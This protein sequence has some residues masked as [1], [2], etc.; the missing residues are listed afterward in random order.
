MSPPTALAPEALQTWRTIGV[1]TIP[2]WS[3]KA[4]YSGTRRVW[5]V[6]IERDLPEQGGWLRGWLASAVPGVPQ[7]F[8]TLAA[9]QT[10][11]LAF[12]TTPHPAAW[13]PNAGVC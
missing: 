9:A 3:L 6:Q 4:W 10:A 1:L 12:A 7:A 13:L 2:G 8:A 5:L 11:L